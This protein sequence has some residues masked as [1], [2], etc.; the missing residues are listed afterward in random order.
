MFNF[1]CT[2]P[3]SRMALTVAMETMHFFIVQLSLSLRTKILCISGVPMNDLA[4]MKNCPGGCKV[5]QISS[6]GNTELV[7]ISFSSFYRVTVMNRP[8]YLLSSW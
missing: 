1:L 2:P 5:G 7:Y 3:C 4:P 8:P 6:R